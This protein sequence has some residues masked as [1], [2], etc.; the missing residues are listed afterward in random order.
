MGTSVNQSSPR[1]S[2]W[3]PV[4]TA[5]VKNRISEARV[6]SEIWRAS[7]NQSIPLSREL[8]SNAVYSCVQAVATSKN[9]QEAI[10]KVNNYLMDNGGNSIS[11]EF[12]KRIIPLA[13]GDKQP[14]QAFSRLFI[15]EVTKYVISRDIAGCVGDGFRNKTVTELVD[16]KNR[17]SQ[18]ALNLTAEINMNISTQKDWSVFITATVNKL[19]TQQ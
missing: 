3:K 14:A 16:F 10:F 7:E 1:D 15:S 13:F 5:Y 8:S 2:N 4:R 9:F 17:I 12:A 18:R 19:K 11:V 6:L